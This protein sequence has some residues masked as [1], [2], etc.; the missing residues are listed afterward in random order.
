MVSNQQ[1]GNHTRASAKYHSEVLELKCKMGTNWIK[2]T[3][4]GKAPGIA[5]KNLVNTVMLFQ[6]RQVS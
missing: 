4:A 5:D 2:S 6:N 3:A 1:D